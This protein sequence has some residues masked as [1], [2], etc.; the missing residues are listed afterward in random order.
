[1]EGSD[2]FLAHLAH[3]FKVTLEHVL[4]SWGGGG[5]LGWLEIVFVGERFDPSSF[6]QNWR[7]LG[8]PFTLPE[9]NSKSP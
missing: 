7:T 8:E 3:F 4:G 6:L 5:V 2:V 9:T 1:M